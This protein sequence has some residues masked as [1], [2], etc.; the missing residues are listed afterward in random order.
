MFS[1]L[2]NLVICTAAGILLAVVFLTPTG[3]VVG[4]VNGLLVGLFMCLA[5]WRV[6][7]EE[8]AVTPIGPIRLIG[9]HSA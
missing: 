2:R 7:R 1:F 5:D 6:Q 8:M 9:S 3:A 4:A